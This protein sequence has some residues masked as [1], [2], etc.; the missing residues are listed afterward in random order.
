MSNFRVIE[1]TTPYQHIREYPR[2]TSTSQEEILEL[3][4]KRYIPLDNPD[5]QPGDITFIACHANSMVKEMYEPLWDE[6]HARSKASGFRIRSIWMA[7][8]AHRGESY[9]KNEDKIGNDPH[10]FD[11][12]RDLLNM[13]NLH[14]EEFS[15]PIIG[16]GH[17]MGTTS[18]LGLSLMH[19][20]LLTSMI[21]IDTVF[22]RVPAPNL[23][24][25]AKLGTFQPDLFH[26]Q[27]EAEAALRTSPVYKTFDPRVHKIGF[28]H[29]FRPLP[30]LLHP[31]PPSKI[32]SPG[33]LESPELFRPEEHKRPVTLRTPKHQETFSLMRPNYESK[34]AN[35]PEDG[36]TPCRESIAT[37]P[38]IHPSSPSQAPF[39]I[40]TSKYSLDAY[41]F[42]SLRP[43][44]L[45]VWGEKSP[46]ANAD[47]RAYKLENTGTGPGG[48]GGQR[49][50]RVEEAIVRDA[51]HFVC[52]ERVDETARLLAS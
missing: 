46:Y 48:S 49:L 44:V 7:D 14:R 11:H 34:Q 15:R 8:V 23:Y 6:L 28:D 50:G 22:A 39:Y 3:A 47:E 13:I 31:T 52:F 10:F 18:L 45:Y 25:I 4:A 32:K 33:N 24:A 38:N 12:G 21:L 37:H 27:E 40:P 29:A 16:T 36:K 43:S 1:R 19:L 2:N 30:T 41:N 17:S 51:G 26:S 20:R 42:R 35:A 9:L 5:P